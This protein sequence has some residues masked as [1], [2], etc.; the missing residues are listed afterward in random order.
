MTEET[1]YTIRKT[2]QREPFL[3]GF[4]FQEV[5]EQDSKFSRIVILGKEI[6][7]FEDSL[8]REQSR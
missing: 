8:D 6:A 1:E 7:E 5:Q 4:E 3:G 2:G